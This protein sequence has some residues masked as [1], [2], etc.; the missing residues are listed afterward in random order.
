MKVSILVP[1]YGV[2]KH[3]EECAVSLFEQTYEELEYVFVDDCSPDDSIKKLQDILYRYPQRQPQVH[4]IRH[5]RNRGLG[6]ARKTA[7]AAA[8]GEFVMVVDSDD[9]VMTD[10]VEKLYQRQ[11]QTNAD[12]IDGGF[13][14]LTSQGREPAV[15][16]YHGSK[17]SMLR[18]VLLQN[19]L[20]HQLWARLVRRSLYTDNQI[21]SIEGVNMAEDY[22]VIPRLLYCGSRAYIDDVIYLYRDSDT[23][24]FNSVSAPIETRHVGSFI[25]ANAVVYHFFQTRDSLR[26][27]ALPLEIG[28]LKMYFMCLKYADMTAGQ[29]DERGGFAVNN[30]IVR[31]CRICLASRPRLMRQ[32]YLVLK[33][34]Y[35]KLLIF[36]G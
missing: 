2:E 33:W 10:A 9:V 27:Y 31:L 22:A 11:Q 12:I 21:T 18:L 29:V 28:L 24:T 5:E 36:F 14:R 13:C 4:I 8:T 30:T 35:K 15:V 34:L 1:V 20:P 3:I 19:T 17:E 23:S 7:L 16:P 25:D 32:A 6:A 26:K